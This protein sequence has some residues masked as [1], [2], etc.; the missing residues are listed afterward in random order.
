MR[1]LKISLLA[2]FALSANAMDTFS[3]HQDVVIFNHSKPRPAD[4]TGTE[5]NY[6]GIVN[7]IVGAENPW[8]KFANEL[9]N[10]QVIINVNIRK[11]IKL[12]RK[13]QEEYTYTDKMNELRSSWKSYLENLFL[14]T[15]RAYYK[16]WAHKPIYG[17]LLT[18]IIRIAQELDIPL[19]TSIVESGNAQKIMAP[20]FQCPVI[21]T[22]GRFY[23]SWGEETLKDPKTHKFQLP[24]KD[25]DKYPQETI[26]KCENL[27]THIM[28]I[29][30]IAK[31]LFSKKEI[32][33]LNRA[34][35]KLQTDDPE[36][37]ELRK[38]LEAL[39]N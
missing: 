14:A 39:K 24:Q 25:L 32:Q 19:D 2:L 13:Q 23:H 10:I 33:I 35:S 36:Y 15:Q 17:E 1:M 18:A 11:N 3:I 29:T 6:K 30:D 9:I 37:E 4:D 34:L 26:E 31:Q 8:D 21:I 22:P 5:T 38:R 20:V 16:T 27:E 7:S 12:Y 28:K